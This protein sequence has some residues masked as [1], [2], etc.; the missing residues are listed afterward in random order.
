[1]SQVS[2]IEEAILVALSKADVSVGSG[3]I[4][5]NF[6]LPDDALDNAKQALLSI[7]LEAR[8]ADNNDGNGFQAGHWAALAE[9]EDNIKKVFGVEE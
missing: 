7:I 2:R 5:Y 1:M 9:W 4:G 8:P 6:K 3:L